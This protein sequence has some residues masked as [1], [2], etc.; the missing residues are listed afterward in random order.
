M[1]IRPGSRTDREE[2]RTSLEK[3]LSVAGVELGPRQMEQLEKHFALLLKWNQKINLT[4]IR[5]PDEIAARHFAESLFLSKLLPAPRG[6]M[7]DVGSGA[8]FPGLPLKI[9][10]P[11]TPAVLLE[12]NHKKETFLKEVI[13]SCGLEGIE[14]RDERLEE[15][16]SADLAGRAALVTMRAVKPSEELLDD[17]AK[18][19]QPNGSAALFLGAVDAASIAAT[20]SSSRSFQWQTPAPIPHSDQR[21]ILI[22]H[23][24]V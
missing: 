21:I 8:G 15:T 7:V 20:P 3:E 17:L 6:L 18:L 11:E 22:G 2:I 10:W 16:I 14:V 1:G 4:A 9:A 19:L 13:R 12:P 5:E 24:I 23:S